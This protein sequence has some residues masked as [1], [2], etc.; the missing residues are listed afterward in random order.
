MRR[1]IHQ[2]RD[3]LNRGAPPVDADPPPT[4][5]IMPKRE[6]VAVDR[7]DTRTS[8]LAPGTPI[9]SVVRMTPITIPTEPAVVSAPVDA[10]FALTLYKALASTE[11]NL[12][13]SPHS[14]RTALAMACE[15]ARGE[16]G[17]QMRHVLG[18]D[19]APHSTG[20]IERQEDQTTADFVSANS[21]WTQI[22]APLER[23]FLADMAERFGGTV[24]PADFQ[25][26]P[27]AARAAV[28][29]WVQT[30]TRGKITDLL[31]EG[32]PAPDTRLIL[33]NAVYFKASW[34]SPFPE[35]RTRPA[36]FNMPGR[37]QID[38]HMMS[39]QDDVAY[40]RGLDYQAIR[41]D[42]ASR[43]TAMLLILPDEIDGLPELERTL[44]AAAIQS[45]LTATSRE[46]QIFLPRFRIHWG[47][48]DIAAPLAELGMPLPFTRMQADF[49]G[50]NGYK[51]PHEESLSISNVFH[52][53]YAS[54]DEHGAE[55]SA[56]TALEMVA[57]G[58]PRSP[59]DPVPEFRADHPFLFAIYE[60]TSGTLLFM[61][62]V[63]DPR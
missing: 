57:L 45:A 32:V 12:L 23:Q 16:T 47:T 39:Q 41:L 36:P 21:L 59:P 2:I 10:R 37:R 51:P 3:F 58:L 4:T 56:A 34:A 62:R 40:H 46:V 50:I 29:E 20:L 52:K 61:G 38:V 22:G 48:T 13:F 27:A 43:R 19:D 14:I 35:R 54:I 60:R 6:R 26:H 53:A 63:M 25:G 17:A 5:H 7:I 33:V 55:A 18:L 11:G 49:S 31:P 28:N 42:M 15:G 8:P 9:Q 1:V 30:R 44:D 24:M